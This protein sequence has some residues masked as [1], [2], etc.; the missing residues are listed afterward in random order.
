MRMQADLTPCYILHIRAFQDSSAILECFTRQQGIVSMVGR[1]VK[2]PRSKFYGLI[3]PFLLLRM[4]WIGRGELKNLTQAEADVLYPTL[5]G[6]KILVGLYLN[7]LMLRLLQRYDAHPLLFDHYDATIK[8]LSLAT[9]DTQEQIILRRFELQLLTELGY[10]LELDQ[11]NRT[12][13]P[14][15]ADCLYGYDTAIGIYEISQA[16]K[17]AFSGASI[18]ALRTGEFADEMQL[19]EAKKLMRLVLSQYLGNKPLESRKL[20]GQLNRVTES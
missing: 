9:E 10:A 13:Q 17:E 11:D 15:M 14:I 19:R 12:H 18:I 16:Q 1:G 5:V 7:E 20:F 8:A 4:S 2:R 3:Q 6:E